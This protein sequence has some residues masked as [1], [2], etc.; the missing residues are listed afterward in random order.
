[1]SGSAES[2]SRSSSATAVSAPGAGE[3]LFASASAGSGSE[4]GSGAS[5]FVSA[6]AGSG[7]AS[8]AGESLF[9]SA[10]AGFGS[11]AAG[12][13]SGLGPPS[14]FVTHFATASRR[15]SSPSPGSVEAS[16][17]ASA[18]SEGV[19]GASG[20]SS[21]GSGAGGVVSGSAGLSS[22]FSEGFGRSRTEKIFVA[23]SMPPRE[24]D[25]RATASRGSGEE[26]LASGTGLALPGV[27]SPDDSRCFDL[28]GDSPATDASS[29]CRT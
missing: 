1:M 27:G 6:S 4:S 19:S 26:L 9:V 12:F 13:D 23:V 7:S 25:S 16:E 17:D 21:V 28:S 10:S 2:V 22:A 18:G 20:A 14:V 24:T 5:L 15:R 3:S 8:G 11:G 29:I